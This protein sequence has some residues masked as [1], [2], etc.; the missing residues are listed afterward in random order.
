MKGPKLCLLAAVVI[1]ATATSA[2]AQDKP[3]EQKASQPARVSAHS[4]DALLLI[5]DAFDVVRMLDEEDYRARREEVARNLLANLVPFIL[6]EARAQAPATTPA[7]SK[8]TATTAK[9]AQPAQQP[10]AA[11]PAQPKPEAT[12]AAK[13]QSGSAYA[14]VPQKKRIRRKF[15]MAR[16]PWLRLRQENPEL[17]AQVGE[18]LK[19]ARQLLAAEKFDESEAALDRALRM[20]GIEPPKQ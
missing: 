13:A 20:M 14:R 19:Q 17:A 11:Q 1:A 6:E 15:A 8:A 18:L 4:R 7:T 2:M 10:Q 3:R 5:L 9:P 12:A 16:E